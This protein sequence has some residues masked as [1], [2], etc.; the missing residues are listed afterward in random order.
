MLEMA[1]SYDIITSLTIDH[2]IGNVILEPS[3]DGSFGY[4]LS[5]Y[6]NLEPKINYSGGKLNI[7]VKSS[8]QYIGWSSSGFGFNIGTDYTNDLTIYYPEGAEF[9]TGEIDCSMGSISIE[10]AVFGRLRTEASLGQINLTDINS[11]KTDIIAHMGKIELYNVNAESTV[12]IA[13]MGSVDCRNVQLSQNSKI[14]LDMGALNYRGTF[15]G[16]ANINASMGAVDIRLDDSLDNY[17]YDLDCDMGS[18]HFDGNNK[19]DD[20]SSRNGTNNLIKVKANM[21]AITVNN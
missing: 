1:E 6:E 15:S 10:G 21:G 8:P 9:T 5:Y 20:Y 11:G 16:G 13:N 14:E 18:V 12:I 3:F 7:S 17:D 4:S 2:D 19:G